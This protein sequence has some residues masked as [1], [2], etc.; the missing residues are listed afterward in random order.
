[1]WQ[2]NPFI[3]SLLKSCRYILI[4]SYIESLSMT[5]LDKCIWN[6][7]THQAT[8]FYGYFCLLKWCP[9]LT[10]GKHNGPVINS[11]IPVRTDR[12]LENTSQ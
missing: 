2:S 5:A 11:G 9:A 10:S 6:K 4:K 12:Q 1:M 7:T 3:N 8:V